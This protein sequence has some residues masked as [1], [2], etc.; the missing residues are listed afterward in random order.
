MTTHTRSSGWGTAGVV[1]AATMLFLTGGFQFLEGLS[2]LINGPLYL[3]EADYAYRFSPDAWGWIHLILGLFLLGVSFALFTG[4]RWA[5][6]AA[7][8]LVVLSALSNFAYIPYAG[9]WAVVIIA[10]DILVIWALAT[11]RLGVSDR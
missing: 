9:W 10:I 11:T 2:A 7:I 6:M 8:V 3:A 5:N 1:F 4:A